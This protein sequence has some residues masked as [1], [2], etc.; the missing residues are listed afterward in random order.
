MVQAE[1]KTLGRYEPVIGLE[2]HV[3]LATRS[4]LFCPCPAQFGAEP[5]LNTCPVCLGL[6]G[7]LPVLNQEALRMAVKAGLA[8]NCRVA[9]RFKFD[10]KNYFYPDLPKA[11]QISQFNKPVNGRGFLTVELKDGPKKIGITRAHL[12]EDAGKLLHEGVKD[13]SLVDYNRA[14]VPLLEIVSEPEIFT[15]EEAYQ[16]LTT[17][18]AILQYLEV[19]DCDMEKG[20]LRCDANISIRPRGEKKL[21][22]KVEIKN[23]NSFRAVERALQFEIE[24]QTGVL[25]EGGRLTQETRLWNESRGETFSMRSKE[26]AHDYRYFPEPDLVPFTLSRAE[27]EAIRRTLPELPNER[28]QRLV[29]DYG[30]SEYD[31]ARLVQEKA[32]AE[33]YEA[34]VKEGVSAKLAANWILSELLGHLKEAG[35]AIQGSKV[36]AQSLAGLIRLIENNTISGKIAKDVLPEMLAT[37][38]SAEAV[39]K[40]K[41][42]VQVTDVK[43]IETVVL[44]IIQANPKGVED[45]RSGKKQ[46][47]GFLVGQVMKE[48]QGKANPKLVNEILEKKL[49]K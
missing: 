35:T 47:A 36:S 11:Y 14:G 16:Y 21:G 8:L 31:S 3:Q 9:E 30:I 28:I 13:G 32:V 49:A 5:N 34:S 18:K 27:V 48:T 1:S 15:T 43:L 20:S 37:G 40:E 44:K 6:P 29:K 4:K 17:L 24:R 39:V 7:S 23:M 46:A 12:E 22:T 25:T 10:R 2:V 33:Y 41:G 42:L 26:Y 45:F 19:S 38:K